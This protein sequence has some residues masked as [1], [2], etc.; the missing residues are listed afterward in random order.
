MMLKY[1]E[2]ITEL[3]ITSTYRG[4]NRRSMLWHAADLVTFTEKILI[5]KLHF[6]CSV[7]LQTLDKTFLIFPLQSIFKTFNN[8]N[9]DKYALLGA[10]TAN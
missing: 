2:D 9:N 1:P 8:L 7:A 6:L 10:E 3:V 5:G 4:R